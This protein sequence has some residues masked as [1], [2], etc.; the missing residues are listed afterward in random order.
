MYYNCVHVAVIIMEGGN[1][2]DLLSLDQTPSGQDKEEGTG[3]AE[4]K[5]EEVEENKEKA[6][7]NSNKGTL[8]SYMC[9]CVKQV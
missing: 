9:A 8:L 7:E 4:T 5:V 6:E 3:K 2:H 1:E